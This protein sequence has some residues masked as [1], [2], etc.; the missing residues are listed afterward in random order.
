MY[1]AVSKWLL[2]ESE[3]E[4]PTFDNEKQHAKME[5]SLSIQISLMMFYHLPDSIWNDRFFL[6]IVLLSLENIL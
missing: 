6:K 1:N 4:K 2:I 5:I 3:I